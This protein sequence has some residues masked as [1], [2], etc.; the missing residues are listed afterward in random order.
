MALNRSVGR[1][2]SGPGESLR[3]G[4]HL[5]GVEKHLAQIEPL[6]QVEQ[7]SFNGGFELSGSSGLG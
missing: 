1:R 5:P 2:R 7:R 6:P 4:L 3:N